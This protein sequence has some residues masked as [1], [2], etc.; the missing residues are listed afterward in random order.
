MP[1][2]AK[3]QQ[4]ADLEDRIKRAVITI[5]VDYRGLS[6]TQMAELRRALREQEAS[7]ELRVVKN[8]LFRRAAGNAGRPEMGAISNEATALLFGY[9]EEVGPPRA[10]RNYL[11][12]A[13]LEAP[14]HGGFL[15]G[16][17]LSPQQV[18]DLATA[19]TR[20]ELMGML[21]GG[22]NSPIVGIAAGV[23]NVIREI[24]AI[25]EARAQQLEDQG[26]AASA[27]EEAR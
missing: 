10:L 5:G 12:S 26:A 25:I 24:A 21:A 1:T 7:M 15:D 9:E 19:P 11:R 13:R 3:V 14:I 18:D 17:V 2:K 20:L 4:V 16:A 22:L 8:T 27:D 23:H 6:V